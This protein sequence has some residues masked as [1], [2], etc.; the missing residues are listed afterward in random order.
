M[1]HKSLI[2]AIVI[3]AVIAGTLV[4]FNV[5]T[6]SRQASWVNQIIIAVKPG[7]T[8]QEFHTIVAAAGAELINVPRT[9]PSG[10][11]ST[12]TIWLVDI[13]GAKNETDMEIGL[14]ALEAH[15][16]IQWAELGTTGVLEGSSGGLP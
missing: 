6:Q 2:I 4:W 11:P 10:T 12:E 9:T 5:I 15:P 16:E 3:A 8:E 7:V 13:P 1:P 14:H